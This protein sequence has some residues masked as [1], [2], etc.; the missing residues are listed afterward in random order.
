M[1]DTLNPPV[2]V[3]GLAKSFGANQVLRHIDFSVARGEVVVIMGPSGSGKT[4][5]IR[6]LNFLEMPDRGSIRMCGIEI[7]DAGPRPSGETRRKMR[8]IRKKTAMVFQSFNLFAHMTALD[9]VI[10]GM[11][12]VQG[13]RKADAL[14]R[15]RELLGQ[16]GLL[17]KANEYPGRLS[18]GQKQR[19]AIARALAMNP[20]V[21][22]FDEPTS[23]LDPELRGE[24]LKVMR[25]LA[26]KGMTM[27]VVTHE[28]RFAKDAA[29]RIIFM[30]GGVIVEDA[31][32]DHFFGAAASQR[33]RDFLGL[34]QD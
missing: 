12:S 1:N 22:L 4:T 21:I 14:P 23:A 18:G 32:P 7:A 28:T 20:E 27:L 34:I 13:I 6:S 5:L 9:N 17:E 19:V 33:S 30:E 16:V 29:D 31:A 15:G 2:Q 26:D 24:V 25:D 8:E 10:E 11:V 3:R